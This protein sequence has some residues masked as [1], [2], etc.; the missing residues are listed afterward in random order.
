MDRPNTQS[1]FQPFSEE[2]F[3][4]SQ[5]SVDD[6]VHPDGFNTSSPDNPLEGRDWHN[7]NDDLDYNEEEMP[8]DGFDDA[9]SIEEIV[10]MLTN[11]SSLLDP[12]PNPDKMRDDLDK[13][14]QKSVDRLNKLING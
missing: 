1:S 10:A 9:I 3:T 14:L 6:Q 11:I 5:D 2:E 13:A 7:D 4:E 12:K 8:S